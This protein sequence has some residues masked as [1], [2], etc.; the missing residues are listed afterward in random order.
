MW[1]QAKFQPKMNVL[2]SSNMKMENFGILDSKFVIFLSENE[3]FRNFVLFLRVITDCIFLNNLNLLNIQQ[4]GI[5][6]KVLNF[7]EF[8]NYWIFND[9]YWI[10]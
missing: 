6:R 4:N 9:F 2:D 7:T 1:N 10:F 8:F 5:V 3:H